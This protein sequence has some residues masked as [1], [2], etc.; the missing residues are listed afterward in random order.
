MICCSTEYA[1]YTE[2]NT[3]LAHPV[4]TGSLAGIDLQM[5]LFTISSES[6]DSTEQFKALIWAQ[7]W[8]FTACLASI[9]SL[10][11]IQHRQQTPFPFTQ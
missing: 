11:Y 1:D 3:Y 7:K 8:L 5:Q 2:K 9:C 4:T 10:I 6:F